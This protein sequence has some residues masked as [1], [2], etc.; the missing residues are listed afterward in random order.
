M[1]K[2][3]SFPHPKH[4]QDPICYEIKKFSVFFCSKTQKQTTTTT[5]KKVNN[6]KM[7]LILELADYCDYQAP[8]SARCLT[9]RTTLVTVVTC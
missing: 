8:V 3:K 4:K 5:T 9:S 2:S 7:K 6:E 1:R